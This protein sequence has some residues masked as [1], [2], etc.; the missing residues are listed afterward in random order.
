MIEDIMRLV[1]TEKAK[2]ESIKEF[3]GRINITLLKYYLKGYSD[4]IIDKVFTKIQKEYYGV[5]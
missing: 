2:E 1:L 4:S 5:I 3:Y